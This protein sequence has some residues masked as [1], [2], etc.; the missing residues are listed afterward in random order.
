GRRLQ[1]SEPRCAATPRWTGQIR[2]VVDGVDPAS[3]QPAAPQRTISC[4]PQSPWDLPFPSMPYSAASSRLAL[5]GN[6]SAVHALAG[7]RV[8][9]TGRIEASTEVRH[10]DR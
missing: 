5:V 8:S 2:P 7:S 1:D 3:R 9:T 10:G 4:A 6:P